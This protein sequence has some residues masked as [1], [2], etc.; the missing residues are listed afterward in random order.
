MKK[1]S[2]T[3]SQKQRFLLLQMFENKKMQIVDYDAALIWKKTFDILINDENWPLDEIS[4]ADLVAEL[5]EQCCRV[6][7]MQLLIAMREGVH[8]G[9]DI[10][11]MIEIT[12]KIRSFIPD[13]FQA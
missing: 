10:R 7:A 11:I 8:T 9:G 6:L 13:F 3:F 4:D 2:I 1:L 5:D 12:E